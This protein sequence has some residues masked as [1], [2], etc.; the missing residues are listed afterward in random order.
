[1]KV[2]EQRKI[3]R[4][5]ENSVLNWGKDRQ[6]PSFSWLKSGGSSQ[7]FLSSTW[8]GA[9]VP[10]ELKDISILCISLE[11][12][13]GLCF[14]ISLLF[15]CLFSV[16]GFLCSLGIINYWA[17]LKQTLWLGLEPKMTSPMLRKPFL[18]LLLQG[19]PKLPVLSSRVFYLGCTSAPPF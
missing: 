13:L 17:T 2:F 19:P 6:R 1:M 4:R 15:D 11:K 14:I 18:V 3:Q 5:I 16:P 9:L 7:H 12:E 10:A 8:K